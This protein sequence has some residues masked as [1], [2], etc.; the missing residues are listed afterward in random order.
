MAAPVLALDEITF[1]T[2]WVTEAEHGGFYQALIDGTYEKY[3][4]KVTIR[5]P[6]PT[7]AMLL[8]GKLDFYMVGSLLQTF[9][10]V[11]QDV[12]RQSCRGDLPEGAA[13]PDGSPRKGTEDL[14]GS[15]QARLHVHRPMTSH[16]NGYPAG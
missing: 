11:E 10:A 1:G 7:E 9:S 8:G 14:R 4:L 16:A 2:N 5:R 13:D 6:R 12:P 3:G 15:G